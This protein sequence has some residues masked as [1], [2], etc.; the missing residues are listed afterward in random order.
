M[1]HSK[2][3]CLYIYIYIVTA[4]EGGGA[5]GCVG[6]GSRCDA[7]RGRLGG[8]WWPTGG[9][10]VL[11]VAG[12]EHAWLWAIVDCGADCVFDAAVVERVVCRERAR[13][14]AWAIGRGRGRHRLLRP[15]RLGAQYRMRRAAATR[16]RAWA[17]QLSA[18][19]CAAQRGGLQGHTEGL[20]SGLRVR[21]R[22]CGQEFPDLRRLWAWAL[23]S[24]PNH[25][26]SVLETVCALYGAT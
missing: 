14:L 4:C 16:V 5:C 26:G 10:G 6:V 8:L 20:R 13:P 1:L 21:E 18:G 7:L 23:V 19:P 11:C 2:G 24:G 25:F 3:N 9:R 17:R 15:R 12:C 22:V